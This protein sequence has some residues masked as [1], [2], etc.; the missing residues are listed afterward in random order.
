MGLEAGLPGDAATL[1]AN[2]GRSVFVDPLVC[3]HG[4]RVRQHHGRRTLRT[5]LKTKAEQSVT[6]TVSLGR[7]LADPESTPNA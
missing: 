5:R 7:V 6:K 4:A 3:G 1:G 2:V